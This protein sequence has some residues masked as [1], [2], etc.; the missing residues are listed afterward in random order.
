MKL[1]STLIATILVFILSGL[2]GQTI[3][4]TQLLVGTWKFV[5]FDWPNFIPETAKI[6]KESNQ[7]FKDATYQFT[8]DKKLIVTYPN[9]RT[10]SN[11]GLIYF[12]KANNIY[13]RPAGNSK[14][15]PQV[16]EVDILDK[17]TLQIYVQGF[18]PV[19]I[20]N[21]IN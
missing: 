20:F 15:K 21:R 5:R 11:S 4:N 19:G 13:V 1:K 8:K 18:E 6:R 2:R 3:I 16:I 7:I 9:D 10:K 12:V 17:M 14:V